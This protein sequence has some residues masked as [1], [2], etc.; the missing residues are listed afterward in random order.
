MGLAFEGLIFEIR[1]LSPP[2]SPEYAYGS[3]WNFV[4]IDKTK[5]H[6]ERTE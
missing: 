3:V 5:I 4:S 6:I 1:E 2:R